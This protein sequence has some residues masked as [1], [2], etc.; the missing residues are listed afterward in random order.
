MIYY[1]TKPSD[2]LQRIAAKMYGDWT[3]WYLIF[4]NN[5]GLFTNRWVVQS[6]LMVPI[7]VPLTGNVN[8]TI[9]ENDSY[10]SL[11][12]YYYSSEHYA[13]NIKAKNNSLILSDNIG[14]TIII[15]ALV[16]SS[17]YTNAQ[18]LIGGNI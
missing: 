12:L 3:L 8:H 5:R 10:H 9:I 17:V 1:I 7:P 15:P 18:E 14:K 16:K 6:G 11:G 2:T 13:K 4:D